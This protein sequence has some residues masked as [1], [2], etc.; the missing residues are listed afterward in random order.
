MAFPFPDH[1][2]TTAIS[3]EPW[4]ASCSSDDDWVYGKNVYTLPCTYQKNCS[5][6]FIHLS[7]A[8]WLSRQA[9]SLHLCQLYADSTQLESPVQLE[10][11]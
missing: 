8:N 2:H 1:T 3:T 5:P 10:W 4:W 9:T 6:G 7:S 11:L